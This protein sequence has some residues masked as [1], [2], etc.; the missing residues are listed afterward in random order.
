MTHENVLIYCY[1]NICFK[2]LPQNMSCLKNLSKI[3]FCTMSNDFLNILLSLNSFQII[4]HVSIIYKKRFHECFWMIYSINVIFYIKIWN[5]NHWLQLI[6][7]M[8]MWLHS[9][10]YLHEAT[11]KSPMHISQL[12]K[13]VTLYLMY[14]CYNFLYR[15]LFQLTIL[16]QW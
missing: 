11:N 6:W 14:I 13:L 16:I 10:M 8:L 4:S 12:K 2:N 9:K 7:L 5:L 1:V 15:F 3:K